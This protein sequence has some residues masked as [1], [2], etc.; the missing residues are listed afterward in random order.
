VSSPILRRRALLAVLLAACTAA[1]PAGAAGPAARWRPLPPAPIPGRI[2]EAAVW[3][4]RVLIVAGGLTR[5]SDGTSRRATDAA[6]YD[7]ATRAWRRIASPPAGIGA[8]AVWTGS[9]L[10]AWT[11]NS[12]EGPSVG[13]VYDPRPNR[14]RR[15]PEDP[16]GLREGNANLWT[17][18]E[19]IVIGGHA[20]DGLATPVAAAFDPAAGTW[21][22]LHRLAGLTL[23]GGPNGAVWDGRE[24]I[25][26][27]NLSLC[28]AQGSRCFRSRPIVAAYDPATDRMR[29]LKLP[30]HTASFDAVTAASLTP[31]AW[32]GRAVI[33]RAW[34]ER[35]LRAL[36]YRPATGRWRIGPAAPCRLPHGTDTQTVW[37]GDRLVLPCAGGGLQLYDP[38]TESWQ[39]RALAPTVSPLG[40][41]IGSAIAW[42][43]REVIVWSGAA[44][45]RFNPTPADGAALA[46]DP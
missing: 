8:G 39:P 20:G 46:V 11:G 14:W 30:R 18:K 10:L 24:A 34:T 36:S 42:T 25:V 40:T 2:A 6:A 19:L 32:T 15:L 38:V 4:G 7:P 41:R 3:T 26:A 12:P 17:G 44:L 5:R 1:F 43:G 13:A 21:R 33:F 37:T 31:I 35:S 22:V 27:G 9:V 45:A 23:F 28:P 29:E 16:L